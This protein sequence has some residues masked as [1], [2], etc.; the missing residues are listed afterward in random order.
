MAAQYRLKFCLKERDGKGYIRVRVSYFSKYIDILTGYCV[1]PGMWNDEMQRV[2]PK[3]NEDRYVNSK[4]GEIENAVSEVFGKSMYTEGDMPSAQSVKDAI[5][6]AT[7]RYSEEKSDPKLVSNVILD[8]IKEQSETKEWAWPTV[9]KFVTMRN[10]LKAFNPKLKLSDFRNDD[11]LHRFSDFLLKTGLR[12]VTV[13]K[14]MKLVC[15]FLR[16]AERK[17][18]V[19]DVAYPDIKYKG[20][21]EG[22]RNIVF[23]RPEEL[24][25]LHN[26]EY[27]VDSL[28]RVRD[29][30]CFCCF[31][32][33]RYS[34]VS[35]LSTSDISG[36][37]IT[38]VTKKTNDRLVVELNRY[39]KEILQRYGSLGR[40]NR[41]LPAL[42]VISNQRMNTYLKEA[43]K[44]AGLDRMQD[45]SYYKGS[46]LF[47]VRKPLYEVITTHCARRTFVV[48]A[49]WLGVPLHVIQRWTGHSTIRAMQPYMDVLNDMKRRE[50]SKFDTLGEFMS[51]K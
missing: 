34:D 3:S 30:F 50:M 29:V 28:A 36:D 8:F 15:W 4:L 51:Q 41:S 11:T 9:Q 1:S 2:R 23:L 45:V 26:Y 21:D 24:I 6:K 32:G 35:K 18:L 10:H 43:A 7:G 31:T 27:A 37:S 33:L 12:N 46:R 5:H 25:R 48:M 38:V 17:S 14:D 39:S 16:W 40:E 22:F 42:P 19:S 44:L 49:M 20:T 47:Q 13:R